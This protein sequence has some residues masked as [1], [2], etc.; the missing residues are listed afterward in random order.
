MQTSLT[1]ITQ[2]RD[3]GRFELNT[4]LQVNLDLNAQI[5][6]LQTELAKERADKTSATVKDKAAEKE[7]PKEKERAEKKAV[8]EKKEKKEKKESKKHSEKALKLPE[9]ETEMEEGEMKDETEKEPSEKVVEEKE[10]EEEEE[11]GDWHGMLEEAM[12][13]AGEEQEEDKGKEEPK[14]ETVPPTQVPST[15]LLGKRKTAPEVSQVQGSPKR[16]QFAVSKKAE[17]SQS[18]TQEAKD[19]TQSKTEAAE[20]ESSEAV[21]SALPPKQ[22]G[23]QRRPVTPA[24]REL[25]KRPQPKKPQ[26]MA[27]RSAPLRPLAAHGKVCFYLC[28][29]LSLSAPL[30]FFLFP[31]FSYLLSYRCCYCAILS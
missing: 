19:T 8:K 17:P 22:A 15:S 30:S 7:K 3:Q 24:G 25:I 4:V 10:G 1:A 27:V 28:L 11:E 21:F 9:A 12:Q 5:R 23:G 13:E 14:K 6:S 18:G 20:E 26:N 16:V 2:Q 29:S 31:S